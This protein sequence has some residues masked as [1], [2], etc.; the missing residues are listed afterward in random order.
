MLAIVLSILIFVSVFGS[1]SAQTLIDAAAWYQHE[2]SGMQTQRFYICPVDPA[3][4]DSLHYHGGWYQIFDSIPQTFSSL[5]Y[6]F[7]T[8][9]LPPLTS[10]LFSDD[11]D[12]NSI[13]HFSLDRGGFAF[14]RD[15][16]RFAG[17]V[18]YSD[19]WYRIDI[20][21]EDFGIVTL[22][23]S[24]S[25]PINGYEYYVR[26]VRVP[27]FSSSDLESLESWSASQGNG[28]DQDWE[29]SRIEQLL[30]FQNQRLN[31]LLIVGC[32][33]LG[34]LLFIHFGRFVRW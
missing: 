4:A 24:S 7:F 23:P 18:L 6:K 33:I 21:V 3:N 28:S 10:S 5:G 14:S 25:V 2:F 29:S 31:D 30:L 32:L 12:W 34:S 1:L 22:F 11:L 15:G 17:L 8:E 9:A 20:P 16:S 19:R 26:G 13:G 27:S